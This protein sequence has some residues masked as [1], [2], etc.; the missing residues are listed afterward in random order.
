MDTVKDGIDQCEGEVPTIWDARPPNC[1]SCS[2][3]GEEYTKQAEG[4]PRTKKELEGKRLDWFGV[5][6]LGGNKGGRGEKV[7]GGIGRGGHR[8]NV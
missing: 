6:N 3:R 7:L 2:K 1:R 4:G 5:K 8:S